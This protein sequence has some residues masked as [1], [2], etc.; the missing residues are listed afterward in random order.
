[1]YL[2]EDS[3]PSPWTLPL[4]VCVNGAD[5][6]AARAEPATLLDPSVDSGS[7]I[8]ARF[9]PTAATSP[10]KSLWSRGTSARSSEWASASSETMGSLI[11][12]K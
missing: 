6:L 8:T 12:R 7:V 2:G 10:A 1:M 9:A 11:S 4:E 3:L 5:G